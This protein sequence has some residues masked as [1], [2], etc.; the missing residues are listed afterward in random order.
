MVVKFQD[1][2]DK[3]VIWVK[4]VLFFS[5]SW[6]LKKSLRFRLNCKKVGEL[7]RNKLCNSF[8]FNA[9]RQQHEWV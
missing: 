4:A 5:F 2:D 7:I 9:L 8:G 6:R 3:V 1:K